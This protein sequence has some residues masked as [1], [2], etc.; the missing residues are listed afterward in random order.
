MIRT[1]KA[2][3]FWLRLGAEVGAAGTLLALAG[4]AAREPGVSPPVGI[5][6]GVAMGMALFLII[7][8]ARKPPFR[9][10]R[11]RKALLALCGLV[12]L[13]R[14]ASEEVF[15]RWFVLGGLAALMSIWVAAVISALGFAVSHVK[16]QAVRLHLVT[17]S[18]LASAYAVSGSLVAVVAAHATYNLFV[19]LGLEQARHSGPP[20]RSGRLAPD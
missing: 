4:F 3:R 20:G 6:C 2:A 19:A 5:A 14:S 7:E 10:P 17:G 18:A 16:P 11:H 9:I 15:W 13:L 8:Q 12:L 1:K